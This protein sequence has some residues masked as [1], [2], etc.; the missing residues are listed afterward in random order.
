MIETIFINSEFITPYTRGVKLIF[1][2]GRISL[3]VAFKGPSVI[4]GLYKCHCSVTVTRELGRRCGV[5]TR[6]NKVEV[7][8]PPAG[9]VFATWV[10][11]CMQGTKD[12]KL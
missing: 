4:L 2:R 3:V 7:R 11:H 5:E 9:L 8:I 1:T 6:I 10:L 12:N